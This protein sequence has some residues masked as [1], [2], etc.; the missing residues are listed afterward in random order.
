MYLNANHLFD[1]LCDGAFNP[2]N[3]LN[4]LVLVVF[5]VFNDF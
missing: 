2:F 5:V 3:A 1:S 4:V